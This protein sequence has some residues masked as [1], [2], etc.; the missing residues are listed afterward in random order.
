MQS[1]IP[2]QDCINQIAALCETTSAAILHYYGS[3]LAIV[4][5]D[6]HTPL[7]QAD[8]AAHHL[9][10]EGLPH[11]INLPVLSEESPE[12]EHLAQHPDYW[13]IDPI[14]GTKEFIRQTGEFCICIA[15][16]T[17][18]RPTLGLIYAPTQQTYWYAGQ[19]HGTWKKTP[20]QHAQ[21]LH[22]RPYPSTPTIIT[23]QHRFSKRFHSYLHDAIGDYHQQR[24]ASALKFCAIAE[25]K[26]DLY[27]KISATTSEWDTAA[28]DIILSEAGGGIRYLG[29]DEFAY[30]SRHTTLNPPFIAFG[31]QDDE[32]QLSHYFQVLNTQLNTENLSHPK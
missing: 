8:L 5:K 15:R 17:Q 2:F 6:N 18:H 30:G 4:E 28:G 25:G 3:E 22:C 12:Q 29:F 9:L 27:P 31:V 20:H 32:A 11:I 26:A 23:A 24:T 1:E 21:R 13:L 10:L 16:I 14:D 19:H 7:T